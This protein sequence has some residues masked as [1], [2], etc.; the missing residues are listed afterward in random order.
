MVWFEVSRCGKTLKWRHCGDFLRNKH[1]II[2][3]NGFVLVAFTFAAD[4]GFGLGRVK[5]FGFGIIKS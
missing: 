2:G 4:H 5:V 3:V 1:P